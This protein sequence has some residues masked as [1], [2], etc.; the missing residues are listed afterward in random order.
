MNVL[1]EETHRLKVERVQDRI[2]EARANGQQLKIY[3]G[4]TNS[5]RPQHFDARA[6]VDISDLSHVLSVDR[7]KMTAWVEPS[8][9]M[10]RLV[11]ET[12]K[13]NLIPKVVM[14]FPG[15]TVGGGVQGGAGESSSFKHGCFHEI[16]TEHEVVL[17]NGDVVYVNNEV[18]QELYHTLTCSYGSL[19]VIT[20]SKID[21]REAKPFVKLSYTRVSSFAEAVQ[22]ITR[23][24]G[25]QIDFLDAIMFRPSD[26]VIMSGVLSDDDSNLP[27]ARYDR[28]QDEWFYI[29]AEQKGKQHTYTELVS[30]TDYFFRYNR[31]AFWTGKI[32]FDHIRMP[33]ARWLRRLFDRGFQTRTMYRMMHATGL[34]ALYIV[35]DISFPRE[36]VVEFLEFLEQE[37]KIYPL[38]LCPLKAEKDA[39]LAP[40]FVVSDLVINIGVWGKPAS[41]G[42]MYEINR[43]LERVTQKL[44]GRKVLYAH[45]HY[46]EAEFWSIYDRDRYDAVRLRYHA[47]NVFPSL[48]EKVFTRANKKRPSVLIGILNAKR[49]KTLPINHE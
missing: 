13:Y 9:P 38:W 20:A 18:E 49:N 44:G 19:G 12:L 32:A 28:P 1:N 30:I 17:G 42:S 16:C 21:L 47:N 25:T 22:E 10:D 2:R 4:S 46:S 33:F 31:G 48:Y 23:L 11:A 6:I 15:I 35:Q 40:N 5:T 27:H 8:V 24:S 43:T 34:A 37:I 26:G 29:E 41:N 39:F 3:H 14:E 36:R 45:A 7:V